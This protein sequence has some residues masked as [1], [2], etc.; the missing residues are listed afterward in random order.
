[1]SIECWECERDLRR[2][3]APLAPDC[4]ERPVS[5]GKRRLVSFEIQVSEENFPAMAIM[6]GL[7]R[8]TAEL[9]LEEWHITRGYD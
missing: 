8:P 6:F 7:A 9:S 2:G 1:M 5:D 4:P 3:H